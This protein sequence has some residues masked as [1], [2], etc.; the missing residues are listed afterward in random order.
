MF[1]ADYPLFSYDRLV[2][3]G[4][5]KAIRRRSSTKVFH[6]NATFLARSGRQRDAMDLA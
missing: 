1:G 2:R 6:G 3:D 4:R 5:L